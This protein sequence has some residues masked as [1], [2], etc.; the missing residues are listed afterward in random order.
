MSAPLSGPRQTNQRA[1]AQA[2]ICALEQSLNDYEPLEI[3]TDSQYV[4]NAVTSW[5]KNWIRNGWRTS[6]GKE[7][8]NR[9]LFER[10]LRLID[11]KRGEVKFSYVPGHSGE[12]GNERADQLAVAGAQGQYY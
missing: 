2:V 6:S 12:F 5:S 9:D 1:E 8:E 10:I 7:V 11:T 3:R 4:I